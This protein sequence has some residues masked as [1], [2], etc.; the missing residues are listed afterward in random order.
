MNQAV[1]EVVFPP[2]SE[3]INEAF[4]PLFYNRDRYLLLWGGRGSS[5]SNFAAKK[6]IYDCLSQPYYRCILIRET[7]ASIKDSQYQ[8]IKDIV[9]DFGLHSFFTFNQNP[10]EIRCINGNIIYARGCDDVEKI[11]SIKDPSHAWYEEA[12]NIELSDFITITTSIRTDKAEFLQEILTFNPEFEVSADESEGHWI[13]RVFLKGETHKLHHGFIEIDLPSGETLKTP[14][15]SHH[16]TY[17]DNKWCNKQFIAFLE[18]LLK[19]D[20]YYY[21]V[22]CLGERGIRKGESP[23]AHQYDPKSHESLEAVY[24]PDLPLIISIDFNLSPFGINFQHIWQDSRGFHD[25]TFDEA[26]IKHG[27]IPAMIDLIKQRYSFSLPNCMVTGDAMG[28]NG[29]LSM[30]DQASYYTQL[31][32]GLGLRDSQ[33]KVPG[34]PTH[35]Q[36]HQDVN[37]FLYFGRKDPSRPNSPEIDYKINPKSCPLTCRDMATVQWDRVKLKII[38]QYR[39][40]ESQRADHLD[41]Q[42]AKINTFWK[43]WILT[44]QKSNRYQNM[45]VQN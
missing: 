37:Y 5:K 7:Y 27:S 28:N 31:K 2:L 12:N 30:R 32:H 20:P 29:Q 10:L 1:S 26:A 3:I 6:I 23:F 21:D 33:I 44:H 43:K 14:F 8:T 25:H 13:D 15:T 19:I 9:S 45:P 38:K 18:Q 42:R 11:K 24:H 4:K 34:N 22:F 36:S 16:S 39:A 41:C 40:D 17:H 35:K